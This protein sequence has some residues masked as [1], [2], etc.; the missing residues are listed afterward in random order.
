MRKSNGFTLIELL[1]VIA[2]IAILAAILFPVFAKAREKARQIACLSNEKQIGISMLMY[3]QDWDE[4][5]PVQVGDVSYYAKPGATPNWLTGIYPYIKDRQV[6]ICP[7]AVPI[8]N[9]PG[10]APDPAH[11]DWG[12]T[13]YQGNAVVM[14]ASIAQINSPASIIFLGEENILVNRSLLRPRVSSANLVTPQT[15]QYWH[16][17]TNGLEV[18]NNIHTGGGNVM[19]VDG[20]AKWKRYEQFRSGDFGLKPDLAYTPTNGQN[21]PGGTYT[22]NLS[23]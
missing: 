14:Q 4:M 10:V 11:L 21:P 1:V 3:V 22:A 18:Y 9:N 7:D 12:D 15:F 6:L 5:L 2:I 19:Y 17:I 13:N 16:A 23:Q 8:P 20:H